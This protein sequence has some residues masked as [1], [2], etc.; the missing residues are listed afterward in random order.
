MSTTARKGTACFLSVNCRLWRE[1]TLD[2][3]RTSGKSVHMPARV[4]P[5]RLATLIFATLTQLT[6]WTHT[7]PLC[8][9]RK[10]AITMHASFA[11]L[12]PG[13]G[14][15]G[16]SVIPTAVL[17]HLLAVALILPWKCPGIFFNHYRGPVKERQADSLLA[18]CPIALSVAWLAHFYLIPSLDDRLVQIAISH[19]CSPQNWASLCW[20]CQWL[21]IE[22]VTNNSVELLPSFRENVDNKR[23]NE[24]AKKAGHRRERASVAQ[25]AT[26]SW[27]PGFPFFY[28]VPVRVGGQ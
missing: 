27:L 4:W 19:K 20:G 26:R 22:L 24:P 8:G 13:D 3:R 6:H 15:T 14:T 1:I 12:S 5:P 2:R 7:R 28:T 25:G 11:L 18:A 17:T 21:K 10:G 16:G 9:R 23:E